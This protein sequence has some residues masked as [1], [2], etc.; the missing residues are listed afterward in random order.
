M[1]KLL[2]FALAIV[3]ASSIPLLILI[4]LYTLSGYQMLYPQVRLLPVAR[5][6]HVDLLLRMLFIILVYLHSL[7]GF[8]IIIERR[9]RLRT[10]KT[11]LEYIVLGGLSL[12]LALCLTLDI[13]F[14]IL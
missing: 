5:A 2:R 8:V 7:S 1:S 12:I 4:I 13:V 3:E 9:I 10:V 11:F 6:I 14:R